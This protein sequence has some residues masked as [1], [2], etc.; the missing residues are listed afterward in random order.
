M[1]AKGLVP[2]LST[3]NSD[4]VFGMGPEL[5]G[6]AMTVASTLRSK[7]RNADLVLEDK[8]MKWVF[9]HAERIG[10]ERLVMVLPDEWAKGIVKV[11]DLETGEESE[12]SLD[13]LC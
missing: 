4:V 5:R 3:G 12:V 8:R 10:A 2:D 11:K 6:A 1:E 9:R 13:S 7:G